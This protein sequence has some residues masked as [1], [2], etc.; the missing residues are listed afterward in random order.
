M[1]QGG[2]GD[3]GDGNESRSGNE[4]GDEEING[5]ENEDGNG[6]GEG[7]GEVKKRHKP[8]K[9]CKCDVENG[10]LEWGEKNN[11]CRPR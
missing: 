8:H 1:T 7:G 2:N 6:I 11:G 5:D 9:S 4:N 3:G 10:R